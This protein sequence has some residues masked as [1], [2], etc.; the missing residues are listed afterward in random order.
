M[1]IIFY[2]LLLY[3]GIGLQVGGLYVFMNDLPKILTNETKISNISD[4]IKYLV[5]QIIRI[6]IAALIWPKTICNIIKFFKDLKSN[7]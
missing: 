2:L 5:N 1:Q 7:I 4:F 6:L 3:I